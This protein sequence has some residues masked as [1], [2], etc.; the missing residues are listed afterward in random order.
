MRAMAS[1]GYRRYASAMTRRPPSMLGGSPAGGDVEITWEVDSFFG[2][3]EAPEKILIALNGLPHA[4][5]GADETS[6]TIPAADIAALGAQVVNV[7]VIFWWSGS[8]PEEQ[9]SVFTFTIAGPAQG[10]VFPAAP[11]EVTLIRVVPRTANGPASITIAW[12]S[13]NYNDGNIVW[14]PESNPAASRRN[15]R[16]VGERYSGEFTTDSP[17]TPGG[18]YAFRVE[19]RNTLHSPGWIASTMTVTVPPALWSVRAFLMLSG[20]PVNAGIAALVGPT[21]S[22]RTWIRG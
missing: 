8:P 20:R 5:L 1:P 16:P 3:S 12:K 13:N 4:E 14:G 17:L 15:I 2:D 10:G 9:Q 22:V 7:G 6:V 11:P 21:R 18:R 19:V